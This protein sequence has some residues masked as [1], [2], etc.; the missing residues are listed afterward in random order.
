MKILKIK[1]YFIFLILY[2][3][4]N[5]RNKLKE[6]VF[7]LAMPPHWWFFC[8]RITSM[9]LVECLCSEAEPPM[10]MVIS[11][12]EVNR[13][14]VKHIS[15]IQFEWWCCCLCTFD[16][17]KHLWHPESFV[18]CHKRGPVMCC[19]SCTLEGFFPFL[20]QY[21]ISYSYIVLNETTRLSLWDSTLF[22]IPAYDEK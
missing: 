1:T 14:C 3:I 15:V 5:W 6:S 19:R 2:F 9:L 8:Y 22:K 16:S 11:V 10:Q 18:T 17:P 20:H 21:K 12:Q 4:R 13:H 7:L